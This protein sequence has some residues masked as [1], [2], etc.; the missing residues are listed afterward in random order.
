MNP[1]LAELHQKSEG[2]ESIRVVHTAVADGC[3][4]GCR[5]VVTGHLVAAGWQFVTTLPQLAKKMQRWCAGGH[6]HVQRSPDQQMPVR[7]RRGIVTSIRQTRD[8][9]ET[10]QSVAV[11]DMSG[12]EELGDILGRPHSSGRLHVNLCHPKT[13]SCYV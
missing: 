7:V 4:F 2:S 5:C 13:T 8:R 6:F 12:E 11:D 1:Q 9:L 3:A 10:V